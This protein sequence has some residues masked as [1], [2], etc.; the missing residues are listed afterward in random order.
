M[1]RTSFIIRLA[2]STPSVSNNELRQVNR[3]GILSMSRLAIAAVLTLGFGIAFPAAAQ[4]DTDPLEDFQT[5]DGSSDI[6]SS[7]SQQGI[8]DL[9]HRINLS[10]EL[11][12]EEFSVQRQENILSEA[13]RFRELQRTRIEQQSGI[14]D[15]SS[16]TLIDG[17]EE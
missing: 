12:M 8:Q 4:V 10:T 15:D 3:Q 16:D 7:G 6:L 14:A 5:Q 17:V 13:D 9:I 2:N 1:M 11:S